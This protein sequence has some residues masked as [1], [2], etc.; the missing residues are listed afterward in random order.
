MYKDVQ[1]EVIPDYSLLVCRRSPIACSS[2]SEMAAACF[3]INGSDSASI[4]TRANF[5]VPE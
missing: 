2:A 3:R 5:S 4:M 1:K